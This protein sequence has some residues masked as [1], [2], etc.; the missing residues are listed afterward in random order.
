MFGQGGDRI[1]DGDAE[2]GGSQQCEVVLGIADGH[3]V[4]GIQTERGQRRTQPA[5]L[6]HA[7]G[8]DHRLTSVVD[9]LVV[10]PQSRDH[11]DGDRCVPAVHRQQ[12]LATVGGDT[13]VGQRLVDG[14]V[15]R[16]VQQPR[17]SWGA[18]AGQDGTVLGDHG[19]EV[20]DQPGEHPIKVPRSAAGHQQHRPALA[21]VVDCGEHLGRDL[22]VDGE[23]AVEVHGDRAKEPHG[24]LPSSLRNLTMVRIR[25]R[26]VSGANVTWRTPDGPHR[27]WRES[28]T[29]DAGAGPWAGRWPV[30]PGP[31]DSGALP[32]RGGSWG[33][34]SCEGWMMH[35]FRDRVDAGRQLARLLGHLRGEDVVV[36]GLPRGGVPVAFEVAEALQAPLDVIV[37]RKLGLP[38]QPEVAMG[39]IGEGGFQVVDPGVVA[40]A[41]ITPQQWRVVGRRERRE[42][43]ERVARFR[44]G[45]GRLDLHGRVAVIVDDGIATGS[46]AR[47]ACDVARHLGAARV[48]LAVPVAPRETVQSWTGADELVCVDT[49]ERFGAVG[50]YYADFSPTSDEEVMALLDAAERRQRGGGAAPEGLDSDLEVEIPADGVVLQGHLHLPAEPRGVVVFAHGSGSS[51]HSPRNRFVASVL[52][53]AGLGT[54]LLDLL[55]PVEERDRVGVFD[56][57]LLAERLVAA[58]R[59]LRARPDT[60]L[61]RLGY[62]GAST[63][64]AAA[65]TAAADLGAGVAAVVSRGGRPDLARE[66]LRDVTAPTLLIVGGRDPAVLDLNRQSQSRLAC[67]NELIVVEGA[68]HLFEEPGTLAEV[69]MLAEE[70]FV[71]HLLAAGAPEALE[72]AR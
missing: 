8:E 9:H 68:T 31:M 47:V 67:R 26:M 71:T 11:V 42:L 22:V 52:Q 38:F 59:W 57:E 69:A 63:G 41:G 54:L 28:S 72:G 25:R 6:G 14:E 20:V 29:R 61:A 48:V 64:A 56:I 3:G 50:Q 23:C 1:R 60:S 66:R 12:D 18:R 13:S 30:G 32:M 2:L 58:T 24:N 39:A 70:W 17:L 65:L 55:T 51:R 10:Q 34:T 62:F 5:G 44:R 19:V 45:R 40:R 36:L 21:G 53:Q 7:G 49:P 46:T 15:D 4:V 35:R 37:V 27:A 43:A 16:L 33:R